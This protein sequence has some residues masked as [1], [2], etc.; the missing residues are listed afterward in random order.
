MR[1]ALLPL[2]VGLLAAGCQSPPSQ[3]YLL[4]STAAPPQSAAASSLG[5]APAGYGSTRPPQSSGHPSGS[6]VAVAV[7][8]PEY[9][10]RLDIV[11][12]TGANEV[13]PDYSA[14]WGESLGVTTTRAVAE[15]LTALVPSDDIVMLPSRSARN[16]DY[17]V[18]LDLTHFE[19]DAQGRSTLAGRWSISDKDGRERASG[20]VERSDQAAGAGY[21]AMAAAMSRN[22][23]AASG[24][25]AAALQKVTAEGTASATA[26]GP[27]RARQ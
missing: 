11:Q 14:Q 13:K 27:N 4:N 26:P 25:I 18:D 20:R 16:F 12:R 21:D 3:L 19:S 22:L 10:D 8:V 7:T 23:A 1:A 2:L 24:D 6:L 5:A 9:L 15:N 17:R